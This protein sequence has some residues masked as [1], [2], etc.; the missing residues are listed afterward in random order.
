MTKSIEE[1]EAENEQPLRLNDGLS[2]QVIAMG[3]TL[4]SGRRELL[5]QGWDN[6]AKWPGRPD[7]KD[8]PYRKPVV[9]FSGAMIC[10]MGDA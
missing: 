6:C 5:A 8:N 3:A 1:L 4:D 9:D 2:R 10:K 7:L